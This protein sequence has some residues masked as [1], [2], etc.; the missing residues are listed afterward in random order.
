MI[1]HHA[2]DTSSRTSSGSSRENGN[3]GN[4]PSSVPWLR[5]NLPETR[6]S[7]RDA[8]KPRCLA[9]KV[10]CQISNCQNNNRRYRP[11]GAADQ[12]EV[13][14]SAQARVIGLGGLS[15]VVSDLKDIVALEIFL[16]LHPVVCE[17]AG[18]E[19]TVHLIAINDVIMAY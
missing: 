19:G 12:Y 10:A 15:W 3:I 4:L 7:R 11:N 6:L 18:V 9:V 17:L 8:V 5:G 13:V 2:V 14:A 16:V 1:Q